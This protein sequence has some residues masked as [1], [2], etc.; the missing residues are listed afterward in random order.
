[1]PHVKAN[2]WQVAIFTSSNF[3]ATLILVWVDN[4]LVFVVTHQ[5]S[6]PS[7]LTEDDKEERAEDQGADD[8]EARCDADEGFQMFQ[9]SCPNDVI[10][11]T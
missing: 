11:V 5:L 1:M 7:S 9:G 3:T 8:K 10:R 6:Y 2:K 4:W